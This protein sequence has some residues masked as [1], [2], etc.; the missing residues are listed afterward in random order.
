MGKLSDL[1]AFECKK[2]VGARSMGHS[3][4][5]IIRQLGFSKSTV[6]RVYQE[7]MD[8]GQKTSDLANFKGQLALT[9]RANIWQVIPVERFQKLVEPIIR[10][11]AAVIK[12]RGSPTRYLVGVVANATCV[13]NSCLHL[14]TGR[15]RDDI[16]KRI[17]QRRRRKRSERERRERVTKKAGVVKSRQG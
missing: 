13:R 4:S 7:H 17:W 9:V 14:A 11:V 12:A 16:G 5:E 8:G 1:D 2:I 15:T 10:R 6:S 3:I